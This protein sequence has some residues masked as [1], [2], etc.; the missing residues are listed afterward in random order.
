MQLV[1]LLTNAV[2]ISL[3]LGSGDLIK[4]AK[5]NL[6]IQRILGL[7]FDNR[8]EI[9]VAGT[10]KV[11]E[12]D[13]VDDSFWEFNEIDLRFIDDIVSNT[14]NGVVEFEGCEGIKLPVNT[15]VLIN[16]LDD[17]RNNYNDAS[18]E[19]NTKKVEAILD[20]IVQ[21]PEWNLPKLQLD[22]QVNKN[23]IKLIPLAL[24]SCILTPKNLSYTL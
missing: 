10:A 20:C 7:C 18:I 4:N 21:N 1:N 12:L 2:N 6:L 3:K 19:E 23:I 5:F 11:A 22:V 24:V 15:D 16:Q 9:D 17:Y 14:Q 8:R 13:G